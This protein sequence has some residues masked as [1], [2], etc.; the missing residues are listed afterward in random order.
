[1]FK[2]SHSFAENVLKLVTG[3]VFA[4]GIGLLASPIVARLFGPEAFGLAAIFSAIGSIIGV[5]V[6]LRYDLR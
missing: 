3:S 6:C 1:M 5:V 2:S 4:Q